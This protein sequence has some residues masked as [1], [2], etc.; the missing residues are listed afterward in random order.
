LFLLWLE[1]SIEFHFTPGQ[2]ITV[3]AGGIERPY[4]IA[5]AP[6]ETHIELFVEYVLPEYGGKLT[7][8]LYAQH[9]G[10]SLTM[11]PKAKGRFRSAQFTARAFGISVN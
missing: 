5:S 8:L 2:Y 9:V 1:P 10:D 6:Y 3:G 7:P 4:S 11:R